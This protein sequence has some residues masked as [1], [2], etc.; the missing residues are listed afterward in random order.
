[1]GNRR[2]ANGDWVG[3]PESKKPLRKSKS[4]WENNIKIDVKEIGRYGV[5]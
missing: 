3:K 4:R 5:D 2:G 1:M